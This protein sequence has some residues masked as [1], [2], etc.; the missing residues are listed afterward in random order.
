MLLFYFVDFFFS[1]GKYCF[2][3]IQ[4]NLDFNNFDKFS[5]FAIE[6]AKKK[7]FLLQNRAENSICDLNEAEQLAG[8]SL[9]L[10]SEN[11]QKCPNHENNQSKLFRIDLGKFLFCVYFVIFAVI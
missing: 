1:L 5:R 10:L 9:C 3:S 2:S 7:F 11:R 6:R 8:K 4:C